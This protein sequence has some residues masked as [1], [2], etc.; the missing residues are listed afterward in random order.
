MANPQYPATPLAA[1]SIWYEG[2]P[3]SLFPNSVR[4][5]LRFQEAPQTDEAGSPLR[6]PYITIDDGG[7]AREVQSDNG[8]PEAGEF[9]VTARDFDLGDVGRTAL[10][11]RF[12]GRP[13]GDRA[14]LDGGT[15]QLDPPFS[16]VAI[17]LVSWRSSYAG[18]APKLTGVGT[19]TELKPLHQ[20]EMVFRV[21]YSIDAG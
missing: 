2:I 9:T 1:I 16:P 7:Q 6:A 5:T 14:G 13:P 4:P 19:Q 15:L 8:G 21:C 10:A 18:Q 12:A 3:D 20:V 17:T 11:I